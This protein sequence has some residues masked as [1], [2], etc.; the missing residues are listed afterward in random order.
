VTYDLTYLSLGA[1]VQST[2]LYFMSARGD[3][4]VPRA[5]CAIFAD[6]GDEPFWV[7]DTLSRIVAAKAG[8][9]VHLVTAGCL[10]SDIFTRRNGFVAIPAYT[11]FSDT[12]EIGITRRQCTREYKIEPIERKVRELLGYKPRQRIK[13]QARV[14]IGISL[15]EVV[16]MK[17]SRTKWITNCW[18]LV[19]ARLRRSDC[20]GYLSA[21]GFAE[22]QRSACVFCPYHSNRYWRQLRDHAPQEWGRAVSFDRDIRDMSKSGVKGQ[23]FIHR[24]GVPL[25]EVE[26][27]DDK[28][29]SLFE[30]ECEG[31]CGV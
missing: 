8:I 14:M 21:L 12:G 20:L 24:S 6:T 19:D 30:S 5:N 31:M 26:F 9:P 10:S 1:G 15:D 11:R 16:R 28:Q 22:P 27:I 7:Y 17:P 29:P 3:H 2:A 23:V 25:D 13:K 4:G 18:P